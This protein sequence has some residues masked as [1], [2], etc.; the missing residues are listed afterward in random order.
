MNRREW[1]CP[2]SACGRTLRLVK[3][4]PAGLTRVREHRHYSCGTHRIVTSE[5]VMDTRRED[6]IRRRT[7]TTAKSHEQRP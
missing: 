7:K 1:S 3:S 4:R 5:V 2:A 6:E